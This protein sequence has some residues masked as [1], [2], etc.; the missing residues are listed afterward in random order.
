MSFSAELETCQKS[1]SKVKPSPSCRNL[2]DCPWGFVCAFYWLWEKGITL[3]PSIGRHDTLFSF[4][5]PTPFNHQ[6]KNT[7]NIYIIRTVN[8]E[9]NPAYIHHSLLLDHLSKC[10]NESRI[11]KCV[12]VNFY[13]NNGILV[14]TCFFI[15]FSLPEH[16]YGT[17]PY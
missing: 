3:I 15:T 16:I 2:R 10:T 17:I 12:S 8:A 13:V 9:Y 1:N 11:L 5:F 6:V 7:V 4:M 14:G